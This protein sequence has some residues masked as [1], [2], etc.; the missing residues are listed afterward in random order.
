MSAKSSAFVD[1]R[2]GLHG[3]VCAAAIL[4]HSCPLWVISGHSAVSERRPLYPQKQTLSLRRLACPLCAKAKPLDN[5]NQKVTASH[6]S[7]DSPGTTKRSRN[8]RSNPR[9][10]RDCR[11]P[12]SPI[13][14][15]QYF[16]I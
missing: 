11:A 12:L 8:R 4:S 5:L 14:V 1:R 15:E 9:H 3:S 7:Y 10:V 2:N 6:S 13:W 16:E